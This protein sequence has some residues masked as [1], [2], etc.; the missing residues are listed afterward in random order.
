VQHFLG[1]VQW[2][3]LDY[4]LV[5]L[6]PG[7]GDV[8]LTLCQSIPL[9]GAA[10]VSTPQDVA[11][12]VAQKA[13]AMFTQLNTPVLGLIENMAHYVCPHCGT[14]DDIFGSG[15]TRR[16]AERIGLPFLGEI[17]LATDIRTSGDVGRPVTLDPASPYGNAYLEVAERLAAQVSIRNMQRELT[18]L[19]Q[20]RY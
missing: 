2:G 5:D 18:P 17:P 16:A 20:I 15:G 6:P 8:Q 7:T 9:T 3:E 19:V 10:V 4:L 1:K 12:K 11:L 13:I 14:R